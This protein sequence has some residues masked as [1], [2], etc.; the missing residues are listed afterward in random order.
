MANLEDY[1]YRNYNYNATNSNGI[2]YPTLK[3]FDAKKNDGQPLLD[4]NDNVLVNYLQP[5]ETFNVTLYYKTITMCT[6]W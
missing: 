1:L 5:N 3:D 4:A 2:T 6:E